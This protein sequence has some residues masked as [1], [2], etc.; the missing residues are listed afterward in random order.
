M[1]LDQWLARRRGL[2]LRDARQ[3]IVDGRVTVEGVVSRRPTE[4]LDRFHTISVD[5]TIE[6]PGMRRLC[7]M[8]NKP[9]GILSATKDARHPTVLDLIDHPDKHTLHLAGRLDRSSSGLVLLSNDGCW[10]SS[11]SDPARG[12]EKEYL[13]ET[14]GPIPEGAVEA[15]A[16]GFFFATE[17]V[18]TRPARLELIARDQARVTL[19]E[20]KYHQIKRMFHRL[21]GL[22]IRSLHRVRI[23]S[24]HL[25]QDLAPGQWREWNDLALSLNPTE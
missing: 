24:I 6:Q 20:G 23:G 22:R 16:E 3:V 25:P 8:L 15:F 14:V 11:L 12:V 21:D 18:H 10:T 1:R 5:D 9:I 7:L 17:G 2:S 4:V 13:V 19:S